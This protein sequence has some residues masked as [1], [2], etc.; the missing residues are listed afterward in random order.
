[1]IFT[2]PIPV[3]LLCAGL[4]A[5]A[6]EPSPQ[7]IE[8]SMALSA[9]G[10]T[11]LSEGKHG[12]ARDIYL[13]AV[14]RDEGNSRAWNGLGVSYDMQ[15]KKEEAR[16]AYV[17]A[18]ELAPQNLMAANNLAHLYIEEGNADQAIKTLAPFAKNIDLPSPVKQNLNR[19]RKMKKAQKA[20]PPKR[21]EANGPQKP[22]PAS[23]SYADLGTLPTEGMAQGRAGKAK[24]L[25]AEVKGVK[26]T[27]APEM[28]EANGIPVFAVRAETA[29]PKSI[30]SILS[31]EGI[32]CVPYKKK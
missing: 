31:R 19:A 10:R 26:F 25:L 11:L 32:P 18:L 1:M 5:C 9:Q 30:C 15:G 4:A 13:S 28:K 3:L 8:M 6:T 14:A 29:E 22:T 24:T 16:Q 12:E 20:A 21:A 2:K 27:I 17:R 7:D 23:V